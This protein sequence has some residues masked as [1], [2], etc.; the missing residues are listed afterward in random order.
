MDYWLNKKILNCIVVLDHNISC[1]G[2]RS[3]YKN[4]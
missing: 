4:V 2:L 1:M 3:S